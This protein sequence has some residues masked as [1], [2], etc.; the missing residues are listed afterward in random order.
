MANAASPRRYGRHWHTLDVR[1]ARY[2]WRVGLMRDEWWIGVRRD[3]P[4]DAW[5]IGLFGLTLA[6]R[7][8]H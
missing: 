7:R 8:E 1:G 2:S 6:I 5:C 3:F 4:M